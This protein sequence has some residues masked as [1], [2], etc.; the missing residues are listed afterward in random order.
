[1]RTGVSGADPLL[2]CNRRVA[3]LGTAVLFLGG[4]GKGQLRGRPQLVV[5]YAPEREARLYPRAVPF[6]ARYRRTGRDLGFVAVEHGVDPNSPTFKAVAKAFRIIR[7]RMLIVEG[8]PTSWGQSP[9]RIGGKV[10]RRNDPKAD[11]YDRGEDIYAVNLA[12]REHI[13]F[14]GGDVSDPEI[15]ASLVAEGFRPDDIAFSS[16]FG[17]LNQDLGAGV[18]SRPSGPEFEAAYRKWAGIIFPSYPNPPSSDPSGFRAWFERIYGRP[19]E[20]DE[21]WAE[22]GG[23]GEP[24]VPGRI[25]NAVNLIRD[26]HLFTTAIAM[27]NAHGSVVVVYGGSHLSS[28]WDAFAEAI[29]LPSIEPPV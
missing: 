20:A 5:P 1:M 28:L 13:P 9:P 24:E 17:P 10:E 12:M 2:A 4:A 3:L 6:I 16:M 14:I 21:H 18:F 25:G 15:Y 29:G 8:F 19:P 22:H 26:R 11:S 7:P 27:L 23:P